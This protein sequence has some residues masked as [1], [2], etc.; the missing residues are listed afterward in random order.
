MY[1]D[2]YDRYGWLLAQ[3]FSAARLVVDTGLNLMGWPAEQARSFLRANS[4]ESDSVI[5]AEILRYSTDLPGQALGYWAGYLALVQARERARRALGNR[6]DLRDFHALVL[7]SG[8]LPLD[9]LNSEV[10]KW[11]S[12]S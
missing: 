5:D 9:V 8:P 11:C 3:R 6:F 12:G 7:Q 10:D 4:T 2:P 1:A